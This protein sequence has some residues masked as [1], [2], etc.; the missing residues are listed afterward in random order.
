MVEKFVRDGNFGFGVDGEGVVV[1]EGADERAALVCGW[2][3]V[4]EGEEGGLD[5]VRVEG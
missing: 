4:G 5:V 2:F 3:G 1:E